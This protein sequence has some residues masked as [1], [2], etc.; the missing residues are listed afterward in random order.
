MVYLTTMTVVQM[1]H[2]QIIGLLVNNE[3]EMM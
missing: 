2:Y 1:I 3:L